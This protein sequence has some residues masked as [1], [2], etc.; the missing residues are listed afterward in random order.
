MTLNDQFLSS[1]INDVDE[2]SSYVT[3]VSDQV[4]KSYTE[5]LDIMMQMISEDICKDEPV[6]INDLER[7][8]LNLSNL[9]YFVGM[10]LESVG[11]KDDVSKA[12]AK[13]SYNNSYLGNQY[14]STGK[15]KKTV[16]E[17]TALAEGDSIYQTTVNA[18]YSRVYKTIK[19]KIDAAQTML[20]T[21][22]KVISKRMVEMQLSSSGIGMQM[23]GQITSDRRLME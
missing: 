23:N 18:I 3:S 9:I 21:I 20:S 5:E 16:S 19:F 22:S 15:T 11:I 1:V 14:D 8:F 6:P 13:E 7:Y 17:L 4:T 10:N 12:M 2:N